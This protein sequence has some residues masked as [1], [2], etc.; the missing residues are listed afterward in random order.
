M[1][2]YI[3]NEIVISNP[4]TVNDIVYMDSHLRGMEASEREALGIY[5]IRDVPYDE[6]V[7]RCTGYTY[8]LTDGEIIGTPTL[9]AIPQEELTR[10]ADS[11]TRSAAI[12]ELA[13]LDT[14]LP[15]GVE[16]LIAILAVDV[17]TLPAIQQTRLARKGEL[18]A[19][20]NNTNYLIQ[21]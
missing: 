9:V 13:K 5:P 21:E 10:Q 2:G 18:R 7:Y 6:A 20:I 4:L 16:D 15:R 12:T 3:G 8:A 19:I 1:F 17:M 11:I 14:Y